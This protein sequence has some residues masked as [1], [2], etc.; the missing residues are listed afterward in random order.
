MERGH[1]VV[2]GTS[3]LRC[4]T[5]RQP[6]Q[7]GLHPARR[8]PLVTTRQDASALPLLYERVYG[9]RLDFKAFGFGTL[10]P[11]APQAATPCTTGCNPVHHRLQPRAPQAATP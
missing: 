7:P 10:Q 4:H 6:A 11:R 9:S 3:T 5:A 2:L 1:P 8:A